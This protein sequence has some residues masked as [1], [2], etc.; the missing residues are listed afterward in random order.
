MISDLFQCKQ[1][2]H[3][4][5]DVP[6]AYSNSVEE[7]DIRMWKRENRR[8]ILEWVITREGSPGILLHYLWY[9]PETGEEVDSCPWLKTSP[10]GKFS[11]SIH[12]VKPRHCRD[13]PH[14]RHDVESSDC[15]ALIR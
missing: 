9:N 8:D 14:T 10:D 13:W 2:G 7:D 15:L 6:G 5:I 1:C 11:C 12:D 3:C 4:C